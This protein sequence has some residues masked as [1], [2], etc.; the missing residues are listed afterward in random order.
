MRWELST[1]EVFCDANLQ[2][3]CFN[4]INVAMRDGGVV[5]FSAMATFWRGTFETIGDF[6][7][8]KTAYIVRYKPN[9]KGQGGWQ[10]PGSSNY[11]AYE[12]A[13]VVRAGKIDWKERAEILGLAELLK[14][15][16]SQDVT[17]TTAMDTM[18]DARVVVDGCHRATALA[19]MLRDTTSELTKLLA[20]AHKLQ[21]VEL[22]SRW[23]HVLYPC[24][25]L[26][27]SARRGP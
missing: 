19:L 9:S 24:D 25:F 23:G 14:E 6:D 18:L 17:L 3:Q 7:V 1:A 15:G 5:P 12:Y 11:T 10:Y 21:I 27:L 13:E 8:L 20:S 26:D 4:L 2:T 22:R 16:L